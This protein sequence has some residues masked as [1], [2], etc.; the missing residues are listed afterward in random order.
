[1]KKVILIL[2]VILLVGGGFYSYYLNSNK[3][4]VKDFACDV[5]ETSVKPEDII[6]KYMKCNKIGEEMALT[7]LKYHR[8][9]YNKNPGTIKVYSYKE[10]MKVK[11]PAKIISENYEKVFLIYLNNKFQ[12]PILL[13]K[14]SKIISIS[15]GLSKGEKNYTLMRFD[16]ENQ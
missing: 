14:E 13:N 1:M 8:N 6:A 16:N 4:L 9:D 5:F 2:T 3:K 15:Y 11:Y 12:M 7:L 10:A